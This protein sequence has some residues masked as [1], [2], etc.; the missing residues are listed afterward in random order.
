M[1][2]HY[3]ETGY[4]LKRN[5]FREEEL[6][7]IEPILRKFNDGW[8][9]RNQ[10]HYEAGAVNSAY[11]TSKKQQTSGARAALFTFI[12]QDKLLEIAKTLT[13]APAFMN[14]QLFF[15]PVNKHQ[16]NYWHRDIQYTPYDTDQQAQM[17][18]TKNILHF[19]IPFADEPG[20]ELMPGTH[21]RWDTAQEFETRMSENGRAP[22][23]NLPGSKA[24]ALNR[25]DLL[26]FS[27]NMIHRGLYGG[28]RFAFDIIFS[29]ADP[30]LLRYVEKE[31][32][33]DRPMLSGLPNA[34]V[35]ENTWRALGG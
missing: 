29:D 4:L 25:G 1:Q 12:A 26:V 13:P 31:C 23:H 3:Q 5:F 16:K 22:H 15:N 21:S 20:V 27:A 10:E 2:E 19:R 18:T 28:D 30:E 33:P 8:I 7:T 17:L 6:R 9:K 32:L 11:I 35:Y 24:I 14:T 34:G